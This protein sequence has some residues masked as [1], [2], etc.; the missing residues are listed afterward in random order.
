MKTKAKRHISNERK[1]YQLTEEDTI[2][3]TNNLSAGFL[4]IVIQHV[5]VRV[6]RAMEFIEKKELIPEDK[7]TLVLITLF[8]L[9]IFLV[10]F[11]YWHVFSFD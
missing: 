1:K 5:C 11:H 9:L 2:P 10:L 7:R 8:I 3:S 4:Q 6:Q